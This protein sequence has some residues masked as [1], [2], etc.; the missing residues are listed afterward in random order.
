MGGGQDRF[1]ASSK[2]GPNVVSASELYG[3]P[4]SRKIRVEK[5]LPTI[6]LG[7]AAEALRKAD[8]NQKSQK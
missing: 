5:K 2:Q 7:Q 8:F 4:N 1:G 6:T 3:V